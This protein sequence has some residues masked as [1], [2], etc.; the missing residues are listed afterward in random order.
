MK[1]LG[2][3]LEQRPEIFQNALMG[4]L[5]YTLGQRRSFFPWR[6]AIS[7]ISSFALISTLSS[8]D[9]VPVREVEAPRV[10]FVFTG[11]GA[12]WHAMG[13][14]LLAQYPIFRAAIQAADKCLE[15]LNSPFSITGLL[16]FLPFSYLAI[17]IGFR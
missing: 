10:G 9:L 5:A 16:N 1:D 13:R 12:Q 3:Y 8:A 7:A 15:K 11:Q 14:E 17:L 4:N 6:I 2:I